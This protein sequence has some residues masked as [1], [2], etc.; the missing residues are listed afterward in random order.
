[1]AARNTPA[2]GDTSKRKAMLF[3]PRCGHESPLT[4]DWLMTDAD[5]DTAYACPVCGATILKQPRPITT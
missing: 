3:C 2:P 1:M 5:V 4:G